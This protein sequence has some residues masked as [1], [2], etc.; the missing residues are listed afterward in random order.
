MNLASVSRAVANGDPWHIA[1]QRYCR[2]SAWPAA[3]EL[4]P[5]EHRVQA[6]QYLRDMAARMRAQKSLQSVANQT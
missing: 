4:V 5:P 3:L 6:E 2:P 1:I